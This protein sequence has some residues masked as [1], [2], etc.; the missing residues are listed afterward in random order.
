M[1]TPHFPAPLSQSPAMSST[2]SQMYAGA[3]LES[4]TR[5]YAGSKLTGVGMCI[6]IRQP[7]R[8]ALLPGIHHQR[9]L[10]SNQSPHISCHSPLMQRIKLLS[11]HSLTFSTMEGSPLLTTTP[12]HLLASSEITCNTW[13]GRF[14]NAWAFGGDPCDVNVALALTTDA[15]LLEIQR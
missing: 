3:V 9:I 7:I 4:G 2:T 14:L 10:I 11:P 15:F 1:V 13:R 5:F 8:G 12:P 6:T